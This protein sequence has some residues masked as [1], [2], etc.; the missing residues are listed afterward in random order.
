MLAEFEEA[1]PYI[2]FLLI[3]TVWG[4]SFILMKKANPVFDALTIGGWRVAGGAIALGLIFWLVAPTRTLKRKHF[5]PLVLV[6]FLGFTWPYVIQP[7]L[8]ERNGSFIV[9]GSVSLNP[10]M[11]MFIAIPLLGVW[12]TRRQLVGVLAALAFLVVLFAGEVHKSLPLFDLLLLV[13]IPFGYAFSNV[14]IR[15]SLKD[16]N[17]LEL[18]LVALGAASL[19]LLP[20]AGIAESPTPGLSTTSWLIA[21][22]SVA[23]LGVA[24]TG[25]AMYGFNILIRDQGPLF[26]GMVTNLVPL[27]AIY[28]AWLDGEPITALQIFCVVGVLVSVLVV[29]YRAAGTPHAIP[30][31]TLLPKPVTPPIAATPLPLIPTSN[32]PHHTLSSSN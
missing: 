1:V 30:A 18:T 12:P 14:I 26:A 31:A 29:Q 16:A 23:I 17:P 7:W 22:G 3:C 15:R 11:T 13:S 27:W 32:K 2:L 5:W 4:G 20:I 21:I 8:V 9:G 10:L 25:L 19:I 6:T 24:G 28:W